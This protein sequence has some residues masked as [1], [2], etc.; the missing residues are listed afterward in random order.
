MRPG[1][2]YNS[3][4]FPSLCVKIEQQ[5]L[6]LPLKRFFY[7]CAH[8]NRSLNRHVSFALSASTQDGG[9]YS[10]GKR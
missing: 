5:I 1:N 7:C 9:L 3:I 2:S 6:A 10:P 8:S 4:K